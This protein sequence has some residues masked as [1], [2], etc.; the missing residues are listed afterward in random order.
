ML[1]VLPNAS[2]SSRPWPDGAAESPTAGQAANRSP[3]F[4]DPLSVSLDLGVHGIRRQIDLSGPCDGAVLEADLIEQGA[5]AQADENAG[6]GRGDE[7]A[8]V[9]D[10][11]QTVHEFHREPVFRQRGNGSDPPRRRGPHG[12]NHFSGAIFLGSSLRVQYIP[13]LHQFGAMLL[14]PLEHQGVRPAR[15]TP[16]DDFPRPD[17]DQRLVLGVERGEMRRSMILPEHLDQDSW[18]A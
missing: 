16:A 17:V 4:D 12:R 8:E 1:R 3:R 15:E 6:L 18:S 5:I 7:V 11:G 2:G 9:D 10:T 14:R 13:V